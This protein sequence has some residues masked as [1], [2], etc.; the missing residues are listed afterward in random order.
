M[1]VALVHDYLIRLGGAERVFFS[2]RKIFPKADVFTLLY[3]KKK[4][5]DYL[6]DT[7]IHTSFLQKIPKI[8]R[9]NHK[10]FLPLLPMAA[11]TF[12]FRDYDLVISSSSS[13]GKGVITRPQA[14][15]VC[16]CHSPM[17]FSWDT[18]PSYIRHQRRSK[19]TNACIRIIMHYIR[20]WD[21]SAS[22]RVD[23]FLANSQATAK[24][25]KKYYKREVKVVYPP[26]V[27]PEIDANDKNWQKSAKKGSYYLIVSQLTPY[28]RIDLAI[29]AFNKMNLP[30]VIIGDGPEKKRLRKTSNPNIRFLGWQKDEVI[31]NYYQNCIAFLFPGEDDFGIAPVEAMGHG[32]PVLAY[33]KGGA[34]ETVVEGKTGEFFDDAAPEALA[35]G[36][37]RLRLNYD[38]YHPLIIRQQAE[39]F[40][41]GNFEREIKKFVIEKVEENKNQ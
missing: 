35:D 24:R 9:R 40:S 2:L 6:S 37:R 3:D 10:Y 17:R 15:H 12:D 41:P 30:L 26:V 5:G 4:L 8:L 22:K 34:T 28:K 13:F 20:I 21:R 25:I 33:R 19:I 39:K 36:V 18:Y 16:Y 1:K 38:H 23:Y 27:L 29:E 32:K 14:I 31:N 7:M 11:E